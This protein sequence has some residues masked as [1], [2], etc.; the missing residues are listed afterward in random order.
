[1]KDAKEVL[2][3]FLSGSK[4][5]EAGHINEFFCAWKSVAGDNLAAHSKI[6][7]LDKGLVIVETDHP[8]WIQLLKI[9]EKRILSRLQKRFPSLNIKGLRIILRS[10]PLPSAAQNTEGP[11]RHRI[12]DTEKPRKSERKENDNSNIDEKQAFLDQ[13]ERLGKLLKN[14]TR[15]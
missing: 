2:S 4:L 10:D 13:L 3:A 6:R 1:M 7:E 14:D 12:I 5:T 11:G 8:G 9:D 15:D